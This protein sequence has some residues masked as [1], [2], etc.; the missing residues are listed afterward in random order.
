MK[1][2]LKFLFA[3]TFVFSLAACSSPGGSAQKS[4]TPSTSDDGEDTPLENSGARVCG[5]SD[6]GR[7]ECT[8]PK[9]EKSTVRPKKPQAPPAKVKTGPATPTPDI[10]TDPIPEGDL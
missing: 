9:P 2:L 4:K 6:T 10:V 1:L 7:W 5:W 3:V 8:G